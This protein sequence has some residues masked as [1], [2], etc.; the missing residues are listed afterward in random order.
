MVGANGT[1]NGFAET[2]ADA[3]E[4]PRAFTAFTETGYDTPLVNGDIRY[5]SLVDCCIDKNV[6][7]LSVEYK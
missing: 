2:D 5:V 1:E 7:P 4:L 6:C 3:A